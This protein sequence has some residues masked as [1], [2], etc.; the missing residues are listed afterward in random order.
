VVIRKL[1]HSP[2]SS[3]TD[4]GDRGVLS[5][6]V[7]VDIDRLTRC[8]VQSVQGATVT[9]TVGLID[10]GSGGTKGTIGGG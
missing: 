10:D 7:N 1:R 3:G 9:A 4:Y 8:I 5:I 6:L 2:A